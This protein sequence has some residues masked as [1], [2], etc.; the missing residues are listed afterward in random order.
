MLLKAWTELTNNGARTL[1]AQFMA[2]TGGGKYCF[3]WNLGNVKASA[4]EPNM[5]LRNVWE[6]YDQTHADAAVAAAGGLARIPATEEINKHGWKC[7]RVV[8]VFNPPHA[9][10]R[11]RA[12][13][14]LED[15]AQRWLSHHKRIAARDP[16]FV[17][18]L[19]AGDVD[20]VAKALKKAGYYT[21]AERDYALAMKRTKAD[22]DRQLG[23]LP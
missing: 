4:N 22:I 16:S 7:P 10:C 5:Y 2:E 13:A 20:A 19:N 11:F 9:A 1:A 12:Y 8:V 14:S 3:N 6:C 17:T 23:P 18:S 21:A 15:G